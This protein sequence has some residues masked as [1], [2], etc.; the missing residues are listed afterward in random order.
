MHGKDGKKKKFL[1]INSYILWLLLIMILCVFAAVFFKSNM[2]GKG[3]SDSIVDDTLE[4]DNTINVKWQGKK[5]KGTYEGKKKKGKP[6]GKGTFVS[7][8]GKLKYEG[9]WLKGKFDGKGVVT[10]DDGTYEEGSFVSGKRNG[11]IYKYLSESEYLRLSYKSN[12][13]YGV[14]VRYKDDEEI[15]RNYYVSGKDINDIKEDAFKLTKDGLSQKLYVD[16]YVF[17]E[18][19]VIYSGEDDKYEYFRIETDSIGTVMGK[20]AN[21]SGK[22]LDQA[23]LPT[24]TVGDK[25]RIYGYFNGVKKNTVISDSA[26]YG[27]EYGEITPLYGILLDEDDNEI[28]E[29]TYK[30][31]KKYPYAYYRLKVEQTFEVV[32]V[33]RKG[34]F[35]YIKAR[36]TNTEDQNDKDNKKKKKNKKEIYVLAYRSE[37]DV[38]V[39]NKGEEITV[40]GYYNGQYKEL[41]EEDQE[42]YIAN[43]NVEDIIYNYRYN[44][45]PMIRFGKWQ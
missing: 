11:T 34:D 35:V 44:M 36:A 2:A 12:K 8:D 18:G 21:A 25:V 15:E 14:Q 31:I 1:N 24:L 20:Y 28:E 6:S 37:D 5:Y 7:D 16:Q 29:G 13:L 26:G 40:T 17:I 41:Y 27:Y 10:Y 43:A 30:Y 23:N 42:S 19:E 3:T 45:Y 32:E 33:L 22:Y 38:P 9:E 4:D 39:F